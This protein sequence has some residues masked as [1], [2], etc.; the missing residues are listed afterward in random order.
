ME[1]EERKENGRRISRREFVAGVGAGAAGLAVGGLASCAP[2]PLPEEIPESEGYL[3]VDSKKCSTCQAC[4]VACSLV[5]EG[6]EDLSL[7][8]IQVFWN[9]LGGFPEDNDIAI[10]RQ[11]VDPLCVQACEIDAC[12]I[13]TANGNV[14]VIDEELCNG[15]ED[16]LDACPFIPHR[17]IW[18][19][20]KEVAVKCDLCLNAPYWSEAGGPDGKQ[21]CVEV[22][23]MKAIALV[24]ETPT[25][26]DDRGYDVNLRTEAGCSLL[27]FESER[28]L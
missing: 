12:Y 2:Q 7:S 1:E 19:P 6:K 13:D 10:C 26:R 11:C 27:G 17:T 8:R 25:Q 9:P 3:V 20:E 21:A 22:C 15:C 24:R 28:G 14:R 4:M 16:C 5:H 23:P 18:N